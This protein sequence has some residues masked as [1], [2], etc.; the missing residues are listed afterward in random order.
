MSVNYDLLI[1]EVGLPVPEKSACVFCP[2]HSDS[3]WRDLRDHHPQDWDRAVAFDERIR[4]LQSVRGDIFL[5]RSL[6]PLAQVRLDDGQGELFANECEG[7][8]GV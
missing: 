8:C 7:Y 4:R 3:Y 5:H 2:Y 6:K 1:A